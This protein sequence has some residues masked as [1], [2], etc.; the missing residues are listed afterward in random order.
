MW[1]GDWCVYI[2]WSCK[3]CNT[4]QV[5]VAVMWSGLVHGLCVWPCYQPASRSTCR[6]WLLISI[7]CYSWSVGLVTDLEGCGSVRGTLYSSNYIVIGFHDQS[8]SAAC[9]LRCRP[10]VAYMV[11]G[12]NPYFSR[13][14]GEGGVGVNNG[15]AKASSEVWRRE[16]PRASGRVWP[17]RVGGPG[18]WKIFGN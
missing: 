4:S 3:L 10:T 17:P 18:A 9:K 12:V 6:L 5:L 11:I 13:V 14:G 7:S 15:G 1:T 8:H 2:S 16:G